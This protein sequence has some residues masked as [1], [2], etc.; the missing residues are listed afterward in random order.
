MDQKQGKIEAVSSYLE[1][2]PGSGVLL[3][4]KTT[5]PSS[6]KHVGIFSSCENNYL[7]NITEL[8]KKCYAIRPL[9]K[10]FLMLVKK[11]TFK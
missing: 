5:L 6:K 7:P 10:E 1:D 3:P 2:F 11:L 9:F 4:L 8:I